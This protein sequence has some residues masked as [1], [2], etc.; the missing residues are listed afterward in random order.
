M[1]EHIEQSPEADWTEMDLLTKDLA[2][3]LLDDE[4]KADEQR[5]ADLAAQDTAHAQA[6]LEKL[7]QRVKAMKTVRDNVRTRD[8]TSGDSATTN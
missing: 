8:A 1:E 5:I 3:S 2:G 4:I 6:D 7:Q